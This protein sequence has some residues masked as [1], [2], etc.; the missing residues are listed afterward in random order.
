MQQ[1][2]TSPVFRLTCKATWIFTI[3]NV[4]P[5]R[6]C[7][8]ALEL[9]ASNPTLQ[10]RWKSCSQRRM[11]PCINT[12]SAEGVPPDVNQAAGK[13][14]LRLFICMFVMKLYGGTVH[15]ARTLINFL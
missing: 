10:L 1:K 6:L 7:H 2:A 9:F 4:I 5:G 12:K 13:E 11:L 14:R 15:S 3:C 8:L